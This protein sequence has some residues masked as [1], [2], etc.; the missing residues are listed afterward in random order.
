MKGKLWVTTRKPRNGGEGAPI[1][2]SF[3][4]GNVLVAQYILRPDT[5]QEVGYGFTTDQ[6]FAVPVLDYNNPR[7]HTAPH[8]VTP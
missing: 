7:W 6:C 8:E 2:A 1:V 3:R 4:I 5:M